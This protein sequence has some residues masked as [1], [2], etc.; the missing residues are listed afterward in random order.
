VGSLQQGLRQQQAVLV[1][2]QVV[3]I[4]T[5]QCSTIRRDHGPACCLAQQSCHYIKCLQLA[6]ATAC[7]CRNQKSGGRCMGLC[8]LHVA[9]GLPVCTSTTLAPAAICSF[10][11]RERNAQLVV[12]WR[13]RLVNACRA[14]C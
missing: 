9:C 13:E 6:A 8:V 3:P 11:E 5:L 7:G 2:R 10:T 4:V 1:Y 14:V 12:R